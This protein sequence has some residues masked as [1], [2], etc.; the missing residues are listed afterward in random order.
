MNKPGNF[1]WIVVLAALLFFILPNT[2]FAKE[3]VYHIPI[4]NEVEKGLYQF[5][6][7]SFNE[8]VENKASA[9]ILEIHTPGGYVD[10][11]Y[12][13]GKLMDETPAKFIAFI[14]S[15]AHSAGAYIAL[16]SDEIYM[17]PG[18][19]MGAAQIIDMNGNAASEKA[20][21]AWIKNMQ[22]AAESTNRDPKYARAMADASVD[23]PEMNSPKG[24]LLTLTA[25]E[26][27]KVGYSNGTVDNLE[28][29]MSKTGLDDREL[30]TIHESFAEKLARFLTNPIVVTLL[31]T[32]AS[33][34]L[35]IELFS[36]GFGAPGVIGIISLILFFFGH[37][38]AGFAGIETIVLFIIGFALLIAELFVPGGILGLLGG[39]V[40]IISLLFAGKSVVYMA[41]SI[42]IALAIAIIGM[43]VLVKF[44]G[45]NLHLFSKLVLKDAT[46]TEEGYVSNVNRIDLIGKEGIT[47][48][49]LRPAGTVLIDE[50][51]I[52]VVSEGSYID[53]HTKVKVVEVEGSRIVVREVKE[54]EGEKV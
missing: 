12:D 8:A 17:T 1:R 15:K 34:G 4:D 48:T 22:A 10:V 39:A 19:T 5:L 20:N 40:M 46:T 18:A 36:P 14:N 41:Y 2:A 13:I 7:R 30:I 16:H 47:V 9:I 50:E 28:E 29:L 11:A 24:K 27:Y 49:P 38:V 25:E 31:L 42:I 3:K 51:R 35:V 53:V 43:V 6:K 52:D 44:F 37:L 33:L 32:A 45:K 21:S 26:A 54:K 23:L